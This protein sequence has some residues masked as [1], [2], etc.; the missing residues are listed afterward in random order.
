M[1][2]TL[3]FKIENNDLYLEQ[4]LVDY[5][6]IPIFFL[7][8]SEEQYYISLC[9]DTDE[10]NYIVAKLSL[11][12]VYNLLH[13][14]IPMRDV[15]LKQKEYWNVISGDEICLDTV[16]KMDIT[17]LNHDLLPETGACFTA[18]TKPIEETAKH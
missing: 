6:D 2:K 7:C 11:A 8:R 15:I 5:M 10:L 3:C 17:N 13:G 18:W 14:K 16:T 9:T 12:D 1:N 4:T